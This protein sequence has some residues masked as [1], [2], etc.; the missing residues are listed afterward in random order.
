MGWFFSKPKKTPQKTQTC[1]ST[2][3]RIQF[4]RACSVRW[5]MDTLCQT[6]RHCV[7]HNYYNIGGALNQCEMSRTTSRCS[8]C[9][10]VYCSIVNDIFKISE[11]WRYLD[12]ND[13]GIKVYCVCSFKRGTQLV[14]SW[15]FN[16]SIYRVISVYE[17][18][19]TIQ[20]QI[21]YTLHHIVRSSYLCHTYAIFMFP[22]YPTG[23]IYSNVD[24]QTHQRSENVHMEL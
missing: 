13:V 7:C 4:G 16:L 10:S 6:H 9:I 20:Q 1:I 12:P 2:V 3:V 5:V 8:H 19:F 22:Q 11:H 24:L 14:C 21:S 18:Y 17:Q 23:L 15:T